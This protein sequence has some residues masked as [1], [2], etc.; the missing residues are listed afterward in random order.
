MKTA[1]NGAVV[2]LINGFNFALKK[3]VF[4]LIKIIGLSYESEEI[5]QIMTFVFY[6]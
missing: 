2:G 3:I 5:M 4:N 1:I 6:A